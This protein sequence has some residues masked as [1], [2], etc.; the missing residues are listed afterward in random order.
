MDFILNPVLEYLPHYTRVWLS[1]GPGCGSTNY[2]LSG[3]EQSRGAA[4]AAI[5]KAATALAANLQTGREM[6]EATDEGQ[7]DVLRKEMQF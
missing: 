3:A 7:K 2:A 6:Y 5:A 4:G 1:H